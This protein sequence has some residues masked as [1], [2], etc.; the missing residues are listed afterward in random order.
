MKQLPMKP[1]YGGAV[2]LEESFYPVLVRDYG[3]A[4]HEAAAEAVSDR[5]AGRRTLFL[6][7]CGGKWWDG[8]S[9][10]AIL[11]ELESV[12]PAESS[13]RIILFNHAVSGALRQPARK[14][15]ARCLQVPYFPDPFRPAGE[16]DAFFETALAGYLKKEGTERWDLSG[17]RKAPWRS[18]GSSA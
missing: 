18:R 12:G 14:G 2:R 6:A 16:A 7:V 4:L 13:G 9:L 10:S 1:R 8:R 11:G 5:E 3:A 17:R 15:K